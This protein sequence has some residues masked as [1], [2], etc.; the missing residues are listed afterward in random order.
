MTFTDSK[1][2]FSHR[3]ADYVRYRPSYSSEVLT[4]LRTECG[5]RPGHVIAD[6]GSGR[7][8]LSELFL[9]NGNRVYGIEPNKD[10][11]A[12]GEGYLAEYDGFSSIDGSAET[13]TLSEASVD[14]VTAGQAFHWFEPA[15]A[16]REF[17]R[18]L[19]SPGWVVA[20]WNFRDKETPFA[21]AYED[22]LV[23]YGTDYTRVRESY[24]A[25]HDMQGFF[26]GAKF[27][28]RALPNGRLLNWDELAGVVRSASYMPQEGHLNFVPMMNAL[29]ELFLKHE[30]NGRVPMNF[31][32][33]IYFGQL[34]RST[35]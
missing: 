8:L 3:V 32:T 35:G 14:F 12:A 31:T 19:R 21:R 33:H 22:V 27:F 9:R 5:L 18:I 34:P 7:G 28:E 4:M 11:R 15:A 6:M 29:R 26:L 16:R 1:Q 13:T 2:R 25:G 10:M 24:P 20:V 17:S 23:K 30:E